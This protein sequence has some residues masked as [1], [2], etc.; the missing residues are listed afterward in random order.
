MNYAELGLF[1]VPKHFLSVVCLSV[2][3]SGAQDLFAPS[4]LYKTGLYLAYETVLLRTHPSALF[5]W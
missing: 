4:D 3:S 2:F 5:V 1:L